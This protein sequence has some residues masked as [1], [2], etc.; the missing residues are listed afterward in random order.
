M[1]H[2]APERRREPRYPV[3]TQIFASIDGQTVRLCNISNQGVAMLAHGLAAGTSH[4]LEVNIDRR[5]MTLA[6]E[7]LAAS[8]GGRLHARFVEPAPE[9][10]L[11]IERYIRDLSA[12]ADESAIL[13]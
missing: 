9:N 5:H 12:T 13:R 7:I 2:G 11:A 1:S 10:R 8:H 6:V 3:D 4:L